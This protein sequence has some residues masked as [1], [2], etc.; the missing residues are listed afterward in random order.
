M[1]RAR[2]TKIEAERIAKLREICKT[3]P[4]VE[5]Q[6][7]GERH[8][9]LKVGKKSFGWYLNDHHGDGIVSVCCK[10]T[11]ARQRELVADDPQ[12][13][14][15]PAYVGKSGW[16]GLRIDLPR[17]DWGQV[18]ELVVAAYRMRAPRRLVAQLE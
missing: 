8:F 5:F 16:V 4:E 14:Y 17:I 10:S 1:K 2:F 11:P 9:S 13:Y 3:L 18:L 6:P 7:A 15:V 12:R